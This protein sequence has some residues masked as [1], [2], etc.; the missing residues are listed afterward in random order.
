M[1]PDQKRP[2]AADGGQPRQHSH[3]AG[4]PKPA[5]MGQPVTVHYYEVRRSP[6][7]AYSLQNAGGLPESQKSGDVGESNL[8]DGLRH[9]RHL[10]VRQVEKRRHPHSLAPGIWG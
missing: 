7:T 6:Q 8:A 4:Q 9:L 3:V 10:K 1:S 2:G 5:R